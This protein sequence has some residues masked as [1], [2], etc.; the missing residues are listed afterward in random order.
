MTSRF[1][2]ITVLMAACGPDDEPS[3]PGDDDTDQDATSCL[4]RAGTGE[5]C[6]CTNG[7][8]DENNQ[9]IHCACGGPQCDAR[10]CGSCNFYSECP[11]SARQGNGCFVGGVLLQCASS[12]A[13]PC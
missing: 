2:L 3:L 11:P 13:N 12:Q 5:N 8:L 7:D 10:I 4:Y 9:L 1:L 6:F